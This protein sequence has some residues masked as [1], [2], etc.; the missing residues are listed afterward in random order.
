MT[1]IVCDLEET[2]CSD[3][4]LVSSESSDCETALLKSNVGLLSP[5]KIKTGVLE[6]SQVL[7][8][9][10]CVETLFCA[11]CLFR[12]NVVIFSRNA[13]ALAVSLCVIAGDDGMS[14]RGMAPQRLTLTVIFP[15]ERGM[16]CST[17]R[18]GCDASGASCQDSLTEENL[19]GDFF[20]VV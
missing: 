10:E 5:F 17:P 20:G 19:L 16:M 13:C 7:S 18:C 4:M 6:R 9:R 8:D 3:G 1:G 11:P 2:S 14:E 15:I 12:S